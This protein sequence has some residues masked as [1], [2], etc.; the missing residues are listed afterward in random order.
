[1]P[2][3]R[4]RF[5]V[6]A[7]LFSATLLV[8]GCSDSGGRVQ[9]VGRVQL[10]GKPLTQGLVV[11]FPAESNVGLRPCSS[12]IGADGRYRLG[13]LK[14]DDGIKPGKYLVSFDVWGVEEKGQMNW[15]KKAL[16]EKY[17]FCDKSGLSAVVTDQPLQ[18]FNFDLSSK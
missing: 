3:N 1:M 13:S 4:R 7:A 10:N 15:E 14:P 12:N 11:F 5:V 16:P 6:T 8:A 9:V 2:S 17:F 18:E